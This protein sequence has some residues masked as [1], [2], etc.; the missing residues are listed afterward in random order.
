MSELCCIAFTQK[1]IYPAFYDNIDI[2]LWAT[3]RIF[4][5]YFCVFWAYICAGAKKR[6]LNIIEKYHIT[7]VRSIFCNKAVCEMGMVIENGSWLINFYNI[8]QWL[9]LKQV[10]TD[11]WINVWISIHYIVLDLLCVFFYEY[12]NL[13]HFSYIF[14]FIVRYAYTS[15]YFHIKSRK[16]KSLH[17]NLISRFMNFGTGSFRL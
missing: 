4:A 3:F 15:S 11:Y 9:T 14:T 2:I 8:K 5:Q 1:N 13:Y 7:L 17:D 6:D 16:Y 10:N 12:S